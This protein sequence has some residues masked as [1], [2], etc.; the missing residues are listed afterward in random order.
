MR[1][2][3]EALGLTRAELARIIEEGESRLGQW[4]R[5]EHAPRDHSIAKIARALGVSTDYLLGV[6]DEPSAPARRAE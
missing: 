5:G 4:E 2:R 3:R 1:Q 6:T